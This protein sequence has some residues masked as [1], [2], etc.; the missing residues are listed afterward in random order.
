MAFDKLC[1]TLLPDEIKHIVAIIPFLQAGTTDVVIT[2]EVM[3]VLK[4]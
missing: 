3:P 4:K 1:G 2:K